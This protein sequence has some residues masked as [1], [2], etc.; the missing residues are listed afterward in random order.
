MREA[1]SIVWYELCY[2]GSELRCAHGV[3]RVRPWTADKFIAASVDA[4]PL[5]KSGDTVLDIGAHIGA[6]TMRAAAAGAKVFAFEPEPGNATVL[7][8]N[9]GHAAAVH[10]EQCAVAATT[11]E[12]VL[13]A[14]FGRSTGGWSLLKTRSPRAVCCLSLE[15]IWKRWSLKRVSLLK[16]DI[17]GAEYEVLFSAPQTILADIDRLFVE[18]HDVYAGH[19]L[20][21]L[22]AFL[23]QSGFAVTFRRQ[24]FLGLAIVDAMRVATT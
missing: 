3:L 6:Y 9:V 23:R 7:R 1:C 5:P 2:P 12:R 21:D 10:V 24:P 13:G 15:D 19:C 11:G 20:Q 16:M 17:E 22:V 18:T 8:K 4:Y 14:S